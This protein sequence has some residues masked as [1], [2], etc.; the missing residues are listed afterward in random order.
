MEYNG[1]TLEWIE[2]CSMVGNTIYVETNARIT[3]WS[4]RTIAAYKA[5]GQPAF[6]CNAGNGC[7]M[8]L[9]RGRY[10]HLLSTVKLSAR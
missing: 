2:G 6:K 8:M 3:A 5:S 4:P 1:A 9:E 10:V 7:L